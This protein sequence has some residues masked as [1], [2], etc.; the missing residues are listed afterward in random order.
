MPK[1][2]Y[3]PLAIAEREQAAAHRIIAS[4]PERLE[5]TSISGED[6]ACLVKHEQGL[7]KGVDD[8]LRLDMFAAQ[9][10]IQI[11]QMHFALHLDSS[12]PARVARGT[13]RTKWGSV[14]PPLRLD[15]HQCRPDSDLW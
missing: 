13:L 11:F 7:F 15:E 3:I 12:A 14:G 5:K 2:R 8:P 6:A 4:R 9:Q 10:P 1:L